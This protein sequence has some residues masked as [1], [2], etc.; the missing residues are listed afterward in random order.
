MTEPKVWNGLQAICKHKKIFIFIFYKA[1]DIINECINQSD[2][3]LFQEGPNQYQAQ[4]ESG[5]NGLGLTD[6]NYGSN[7]F[8]TYGYYSSLMSGDMCTNSCLKYGFIYA[9]IEPK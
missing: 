5:L 3:K 8:T 1:A 9:A 2:W 4:N 7:G 6:Y